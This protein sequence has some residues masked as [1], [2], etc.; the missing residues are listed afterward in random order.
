M[1]AIK[2]LAGLLPQQDER[3]KQKEGMSQSAHWKGVIFGTAAHVG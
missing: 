1:A 3:A 2:I